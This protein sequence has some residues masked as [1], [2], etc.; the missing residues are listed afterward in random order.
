MSDAPK[1]PAEN[2]EVDS[3]AALP[4]GW[5]PT[6]DGSSRYWNGTAWTSLPVPRDVGGRAQPRRLRKRPSR[7]ALIVTSA[8]VV[9]LLAG[10]GTA[11][12]VSADASVSAAKAAHAKVLAAE[13]KKAAEQEAATYAEQQK[14]AAKEAA[15]TAERTAR[16][17]SVKEIEASVKTMATTDATTGVITGPILSASCSP[18]NGGSTDDLTAQ[19]TVFQCFVA[20]KNNADGTQSGYYFHATMNWTAS[21]Y[22]YGLGNTGN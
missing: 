3:G 13:K 1:I 22:T 6:P 9:L 16:A 20:D 12:K 8:I 10:G 5:Y 7:R 4:A 18:V 17:A 14:E 11:W 15:D 21:T 19:T 2:R